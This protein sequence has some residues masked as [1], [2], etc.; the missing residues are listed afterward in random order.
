[1]RKNVRATTTA[2]GTRTKH[3]QK[4]IHNE[5]CNVNNITIGI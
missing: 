2:N 5:K 1:M 4:E 3:S